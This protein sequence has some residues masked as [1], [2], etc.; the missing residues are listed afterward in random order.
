[1]NKKPKIV[2]GLS[3]SIILV[4]GVL[5]FVDTNH[6]ED[7]IKIGIVTPLTGDAAFWGESS[8]YG[9]KLAQIDLARINVEFILEDCQLDPKKAL[10]TIQKLVNVDNVDA[11]Y[12]E[13]TPA[14][15]TGSSVL[16]NKDILHVY[17]A[18]VESPL[19]ESE[20]NYKTYV[21][22]RKN[23]KNAA[24]YLKQEGIKKVGILKMNLEFAELCKQGIE[25]VY[26]NVIVE[27][28][29]PGETDFRTMI[30][31]MKHKNITA[32]FN[33]AFPREVQSSLMQKEQLGFDVKFFITPSD[34]LPV[35]FVNEN[36]SLMENV[37]TF[38]FPDVSN[39]FIDR[40]NREFDNPDIAAP[41]AAAV[42]Y[43][44]LK[45]IANSLNKCGKDII[46]IRNEMDNAPPAKE[47]GFKGFKNRI[48]Q[49]DS[50]IKQWN[51][52]EFVKIKFTSI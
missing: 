3:I 19:K 11:V 15:I 29:N 44:H 20:N 41:E 21:D 40:L 38:G 50:P 36:P 14:A 13:F 7:E 25:E 26:S 42:T 39:E 18:A 35:N 12:T 8:V 52:E 45:Q 27:G 6:S 23:C 28:Y 24:L 47:I 17:D 30:L 16:K 49:F 51:G 22:Y 33:P 10:N 48:A 32:V 43:I 31:K 1:M 5:A 37:I 2:L 46:C 9:M 34:A 4:F